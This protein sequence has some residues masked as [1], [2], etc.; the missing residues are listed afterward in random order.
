MQLRSAES[1]GNFELWRDC[2]GGIWEIG[3]LSLI[4][5]MGPMKSLRSQTTIYNLSD[6]FIPVP[7]C[8]WRLE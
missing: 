1:V 2:E 5:Q 6:L 4:G 7:K 8:Y 3:Q